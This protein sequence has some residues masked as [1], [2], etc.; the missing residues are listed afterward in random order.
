M[1]GCDRFLKW[2]RERESVTVVK[3][4]IVSACAVGNCEKSDLPTVSLT[5][6]TACNIKHHL[7]WFNGAG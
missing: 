4:A 2:D 5:T 1:S 3:S 7:A 6:S